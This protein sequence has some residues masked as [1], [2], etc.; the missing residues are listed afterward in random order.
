MKAIPGRLAAGRTSIR[1]VGAPW[2]GSQSQAITPTVEQV[3]RG[4]LKEDVELMVAVVQ[5][6]RMLQHGFTS[7]HQGVPTTCLRA[8]SVGGAELGR[9]TMP[10]DIVSARCGSSRICCS[11]HQL[12]NFNRHG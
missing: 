1:S 4:M 9:A 3:I 10:E 11:G 5:Q 6:G 12:S 8:R 7:H 2:V